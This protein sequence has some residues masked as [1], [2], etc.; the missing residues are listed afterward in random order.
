MARAIH[1]GAAAAVVAL[2]AALRA[3]PLGA[4][5]PYFSYVDEGHVLRPAARMVALGTWDPGFY[6]YPSLVPEAIAIAAA[7]GAPV[8]ARV[9]GRALTADARRSSP[10]FYDVVEPPLLL[11][12]ACGLV[13]AASVATVVVVLILGTRLAGRRAGL[14]AGLLAAVVPALV[15]RGAIV[16]VDT[17]AALLATLVLLLVVPPGGTR[18]GAGRAALAGAVAGLAG[19]AKYTAGAVL[20]A[21]GPPIAA[22]PAGRRV[23][24]VLAAAAS[25]AGAA[26][27]AMPALWLRPGAVAHEL[28][29]QRGIYARYP[30]TPSYL[31]AALGAGELGVPFLLAAGLGLAV[32]LA[33]PRSRA[34]TAGWCAFTAI[35]LAA[36]LGY[37]FQ[38]FRNVLPLVPFACVAAGA[39]IARLDD[40]IAAR[41]APR[42]TAALLVALALAGGMLAA[43]TLPDV[44]R[45]AGLVDTRAVARAW[46]KA[47]VRPGERVLVV[48]ELA[49]L[50]SELD[51]L[52]TRVDVVPWAAVP[53]AVAG[54]GYDWV[55]GGDAARPWGAAAFTAA[56]AGR[57]LRARFGHAPMGGPTTWRGNQEAVLVYGPP[58]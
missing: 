9:T 23:R 7:A 31:T 2:A 58:P 20:A 15:G 6:R 12:I 32:L 41:G 14:A 13:W 52:G 47:H 27:L 22:T 53:A 35:L 28:G 54:G 33:A 50:P 11:A 42:G 46:L 19:T 26:V 40:L 39:G 8:Y 56:V 30:P 36:L 16:T 21:V 34:V 37:R 57:P 18:L 55:V 38:P 5:F 51:R 10:R 1:L 49:M 48:E 29:F 24:L 45:R 17:P 44:R 3:M 25:A 43:G 4:G